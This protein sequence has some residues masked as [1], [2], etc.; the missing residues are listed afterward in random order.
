MSRKDALMAI[1]AV[2]LVTSLSLSMQVP[3]NGTSSTV[4]LGI[5]RE[6]DLVSNIGF[7]NPVNPDTDGDGLWDSEEPKVGTDPTNPDTDGDGL[8][9]GLECNI[10][11]DPSSRDTDWDGLWDGQEVR[12]NDHD[13]FYTGTN[14]L[15]YDTDGD[16]VGDFED[17]E[18]DDHLANGNEWRYDESTGRPL[19]WT[20]PQNA[21]TDGDGVLDGYEVYGNPDNAD[22]TSDPRR[23]DTDGDK[24]TDDIDPRTWVKEFLPFSRIQG[25]SAINGPVYPTAAVKGMPFTVEGWVEI[26]CTPYS[27]RD[28]GNW[29]RAFEPM[30]VQVFIVQ[31]GLMIP[32]S[33]EMVTGDRGA[34]EVV[35]TIG[36]EVM[37]NEGVLTITTTH[38]QKVVYWPV[39]WDEIDGN[40][41]PL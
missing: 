23:K 7:N 32:I 5:T 11:T 37:V 9:D 30:M 15:K 38:Y 8:W 17:D 21:D 35:C 14:P 33:D 24:L 6:T 39:L 3:S 27:G 20:G 19:R 40:D 22:Q 1:V 25:N 13:E 2:L 18:D 29:R 12:K 34:F 41:L 26:N 36:D 4:P 28:T 10:S 16:G 31:D